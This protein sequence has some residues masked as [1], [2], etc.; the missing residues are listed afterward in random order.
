MPGMKNKQS[1]ELQGRREDPTQIITTLTIS[2]VL[3]IWV[4]QP[5]SFP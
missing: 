2:R 1:Q 3:G 5:I 4:G